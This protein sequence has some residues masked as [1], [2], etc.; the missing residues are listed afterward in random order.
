MIRFILYLILAGGFAIVVSWFADQQGQTSIVWQNIE[1]TLPTSLAIGGIIASFA[2]VGFI[3]WLTLKFL[4][5][6]G[7]IAHNWRERRRR[8]G[9]KALAIGMVA[10]AAG[11]IK[12]ARKQVK[13]SEKLLGSGILSDLLSAQTAHAAGD[14]KASLRYFTALAKDKQT[15]YFGQI[16][17][18]RLYHE[19]GRFAESANAAEQALTLEKNSLPAMMKLLADALAA[20]NWQAA[21]RWVDRLIALK[22]SEQKHPIAKHLLPEAGHVDARLLASGQ[23]AH[24]PLLAAYLCLFIAEQ[25][26]DDAQRLT[27]LKLAAD[28][29]APLPVV[30][31]KCAELE[32]ETK[33][34]A[35][36]KR[37]ENA[38]IRLPHSTF[39]TRLKQLSGVNDGQHIAKL[40]K[41]AES[42]NQQDDALLVVAEQALE[43]GIWAAAS[44]ALSQISSAGHTNR[45]YMVS[46]RLAETVFDSGAQSTILGKEDA[47]FEAATAPHG[48]GWYCAGCHAPQPDTRQICGDCGVVGQIGW[49]R[50]YNQPDDAKRLAS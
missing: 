34:K 38:F 19:T 27:W 21:H 16:G 23:L 35:A 18:M 40:S 43:C 8:D 15:A 1:I 10:F 44:A 39:A 2:I 47:M 28:Y 20:S 33:P 45:Y 30:V 12:G 9:E 48:V 36:I 22:L 3:L 25:Q 7:L 24:L 4:S 26:E 42:S 37:L 11:D 31:T 41:L 32:A 49:M 17:L 6:P 13:K 46:A 29:P 5:W 50:I 14:N